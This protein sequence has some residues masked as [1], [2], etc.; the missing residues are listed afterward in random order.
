MNPTDKFLFD[1][2][3]GRKA[4]RRQEAVPEPKYTEA[5][6]AA[7]RGD[8]QRAGIAMGLEQAGRQI[9]TLTAATLEQIA[10]GL[11]RLAHEHEQALDLVRADAVRLAVAAAARLA[12]ELIRRQPAV[13]VEA[14]VAELLA[15]L[16]NEPRVV[17]RV[18]EALVEP[19]SAR[20]DAFARRPGFEGRIVLL[21]EP[22]L[23]GADC[24]VEWA[25][26]G[27]ERDLGGLL[28]SLDDSVR[29]YCDRR[30]EPADAAAGEDRLPPP[31][32]ATARAAVADDPFPELSDDDFDPARW[33]RGGAEE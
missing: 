30:H 14:L 16:P 11:E 1:T 4:K 5:D 20:V 25:D 22:W 15:R 26:G 6:L 32:G 12:P 13:E 27:A 9:E 24:R 31:A 18:A 19:L 21:G 3:F 7:A 2:E 17:V 33:G 10:G 29:R 28:A 23:D 8:G